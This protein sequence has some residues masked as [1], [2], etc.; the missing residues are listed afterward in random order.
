VN[1][2]RL[3]FLMIMEF[4][5]YYQ[6]LGVEKTASPGEIKKAY[7]KLA[8]LYHPDRNNGDPS[9]ENKFKEV[10][11]A[12][13]VLS[14]PLKRSKYDNMSANAFAYNRS[15]FGRKYSSDRGPTNFDFNNL[16][17]GRSS[18]Y[19]DFFE[20][21]FRETFGQNSDWDSA[22][23]QF[24]YESSEPVVKL[25]V[26]EA[27][28]GAEKIIKIYGST[29]SVKIP[30]GVRDGSV[31]KMRNINSGNEISLRIKIVDDKYEIKKSDLSIEVDADIFTAV[32]G[33]EL[34]FESPDSRVISFHVNPGTDSGKTYKFTG[35]GL[36]KDESK[37]QRGDLFV[38]IRLT[39]PKRLDETSKKDF[40]L[41]K[42]KIG[43]K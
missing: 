32:L 13:E 24:K 34:N 2:A 27:I 14:D 29:L 12:Y 4:K 40:A 8:L 21:F 36:Y 26:S 6:I 10:N 37:N 23:N 42:R 43:Q 19:S 11:E 7:R 39:V 5:N 25:N 18:G 16:F 35:L 33:G 38:K 28:N 41:L 1:A 3:Y 31:L 30:G 22:S 20:S 9:A 15:G 17:G